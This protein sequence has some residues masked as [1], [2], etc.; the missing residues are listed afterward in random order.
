MKR[1]LFRSIILSFSVCL[2]VSFSAFAQ[3]FQ[4]SYRIGAGG[5]INIRNISGDVKVTGYNGD[6]V[7]VTAFKEGRDRDQVSVEDL[8]S[9]NG[10]DVRVK[11]PENCN[12]NASVRFEVKAPSEMRY[13]YESLS[14]VSGD[15]EVDNLSGDLRVKSVSGNVTVRG[16]AGSVSASSVSGNV[17]VGDVNGGANAKSTS[18]NVEVEIRSLEGAESM[19]FASVS[20]N[21]RVKLPGNL[22][23]DVKMSTMSGDLKTDFP[24]QIEEPKYG[25]GRKVNGRL[26]GGSRSLKMSSVSG[27]VS[28]LRM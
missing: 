5:T 9:G 23:A 4:R 27:S 19:D 21:V 6:A 12:C 22:D 20:G 26:G 14:S 8:S 15:V 2:F 28:L 11:Y 25:P 10:V 17:I 18:G 3:D 7:I 13:R 24:L 1:S 16:A